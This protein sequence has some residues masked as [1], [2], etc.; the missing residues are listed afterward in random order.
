MNPSSPY[1]RPLYGRSGYAHSSRSPSRSRS[2]S[3]YPYSRSRSASRSRSRS[4]SPRSPP[5]PRSLSRERTDPRRLDSAG[6]AGAY[7][8]L[9]PRSFHRSTSPGPA[10]PPPGDVP[11]GFAVAHRWPA[12]HGQGHVCD[13]LL[14]PLVQPVP[15]RT[16]SP[17]PPPFLLL[18]RRPAPPAIPCVY[19]LRLPCSAPAIAAQAE[20]V[21]GRTRFTLPVPY[22]SHCLPP[23]SSHGQPP[24]SP[25][26]SSVISPACTAAGRARPTRRSR[27]VR[28]RGRSTRT[29]TPLLPLSPCPP[30]PLRCRLVVRL[31]LRRCPLLPP[32]PLPCF[33]VAV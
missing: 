33:L 23:P 32:S 27:Q 18:L 3:P 29:T 17:S 1:S 6:P 24:S 13:A 11:I 16:S 4:R 9:P 25:A 19:P 10:Y 28:R 12:G 8:P 5:R 26:H 7:A 14:L 22:L 21:Q 15:S 2:R 30:L 20:R 31:L